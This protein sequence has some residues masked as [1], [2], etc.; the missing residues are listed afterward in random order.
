MEPHFAEEDK[1]LFYK[2][3]DKASTYFE[4]GSGGSTNQ[5]YIRENI[6]KIY[7]VESDLIWHNKAKKI[8]KNNKIHHIF[9]DMNTLPMTWGNPGPKATQQQMINYSDQIKK[10]K[11]EEIQ[12]IDLILIDGRFRVACCLKCYDLINDNCLIAFDDFLNRKHYH[13][14]L[15]F[16]D[17]IDSTTDKRMV[18]LKKKK[19][20]ILDQLIKRYELIKS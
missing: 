14:V 9:N 3:L 2:Y 16:F 7:S 10:L 19:T 5:A 1:K 15:D 12:D 6:K 18:I 4:F 13:I 20:P 8:M 17:I 11:K